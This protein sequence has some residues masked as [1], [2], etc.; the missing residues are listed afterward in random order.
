L[1]SF[2]SA[3][4]KDDTHLRVEDAVRMLIREGAASERLFPRLRDACEE[5][6]VQVE[7]HNP[8][9]VQIDSSRVSC[10]IWASSKKYS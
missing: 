4:A 8:F 1:S 3:A 10:G 7:G 2:G 6:V 9:T 5:W